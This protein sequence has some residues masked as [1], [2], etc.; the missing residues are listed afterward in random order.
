MMELTNV[1]LTI[2]MAFLVKSSLMAEALLGR[3]N[4]VFA[5]TLDNG[6][7]FDDDPFTIMDAFEASVS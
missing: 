2:S 3:L 5:R 4:R 7:C 6:R 1:V